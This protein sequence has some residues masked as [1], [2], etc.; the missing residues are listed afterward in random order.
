MNGTVTQDENIKLKPCAA[1]MF[2]ILFYYTLHILFLV[3]FRQNRS[4]QLQLGIRSFDLRANRL[5]IVQK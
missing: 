5:F 4:I 3:G 1:R 2:F